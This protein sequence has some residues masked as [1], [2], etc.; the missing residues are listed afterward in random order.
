MTR[1][2]EAAAMLLIAKQPAALVSGPGKRRK[3]SGIV[4]PLRRLFGAAQ[5]QGNGELNT[6]GVMTEID[7]MH[8]LRSGCRQSPEW[9]MAGQ[10]GLMHHA[11]SSG[12]VLPKP[13]APSISST[14]AQRPAPL[15]C[16]PGRHH[17]C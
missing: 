15:P 4:A 16:A 5:A 7:R 1:F 12:I 10:E 3:F 14:R 8:A 2:P 9:R 6:G 17:F 11:A 13:A